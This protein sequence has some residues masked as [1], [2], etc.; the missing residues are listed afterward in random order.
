MLRKL[1]L[2][3]ALFSSL[4]VVLAVLTVSANPMPG[5]NPGDNLLPIPQ[6]SSFAKETFAFNKNWAIAP[7][8]GISRETGAVNSLI[9][10]TQERFDIPLKINAAPKAATATQPLIRL[11]MKPG[12]VAI[13]KTTDKNVEDLKK[14]AYRLKLEANEIIITANA[15]AGLFYGVQSLL[16][17]LTR[18]DENKVVLPKGE[19]T[20]WPDLEVRSIY[21]DDAHHLERIPAL[22]RA[23]RQASYFKING[24]ALKLEGHFQFVSAK[25]IVEP[26]AL[27]PAEYQDLANYAKARFVEL[28]PFLDVPAHISFILKHPAYAHL[29]AYPNNNYQM[30]MVS[31]EAEKLLLDMFGELIDASKGGKYVFLSNDEAYYAG[32]ADNEKAEAAKAG[33]NG[34]FLAKFIK[35]LADELYKKGRISII[36]GEYP[37]NGED[38]K[39]LPKHLVNGVYDGSVAEAYRN[40]GN[41]QNIY[42]S[43][44][45]MEPLFPSY[46]TFPANKFP[47][48]ESKSSALV[49]DDEMAQ[50]EL[51]KGRVEGVVKTVS[52]AIAQ[53]KSDFMGMLV[54]GWGD[55]GLN[56]E[57]FWLG[58]AAG[59]SAGWSRGSETAQELTDR[60]YASFYGSGTV[61]INRVYQ[62]LSSQAQF[63]NDSWDWTPSELRTPI[64]GNSEGIFDTPKH[65]KDQTLSLLPIPAAKTFSLDKDW[66]ANNAL[67]LKATEKYLQENNELIELLQKNIGSADFQQYNL[68]ILLSIAQ[69]CRQ[70]LNML[71]D[72]KRISSLLKLSSD[73]SA[74]SAPAAISL[75]DQALDQAKEIRSER[76]ETYQSMVAAWYEEWLPRVAEANGRVYLDQVD[77]VKDHV[78]MRTADMTYLIYR[79][80]NYPLEKWYEQVK[81]V[82]NQRAKEI[83]LPVRADLLNWKNTGLQP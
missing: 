42:T 52:S 72:F 45:G 4:L 78:P 60:F 17:L 49:T 20:D 54:A 21:W 2:P 55:S 11:V 68:R 12:S 71:L 39:F 28:M 5:G 16:Q 29:R 41:R 18:Q 64:V 14:Q 23:I 63:W 81:E 9:T 56:P 31:P 80:L 25:P 76:N 77:D 30:S 24:F 3:S 6:K 67:R 61:N 40:N 50:G 57:T 19:I 82:R 13:G 59:A 70:E 75:L 46:F 66:I 58:Y 38:V 65:L 51:E 79:Q 1:H 47:L 73:L 36:W 44:Q 83:N 35:R 53:N 7:G 10:E 15:P 26:Y 34:A 8:A 43:T 33:G 37:L 22:K 32:K 27:T 62:L 69:L 74:T 48:S